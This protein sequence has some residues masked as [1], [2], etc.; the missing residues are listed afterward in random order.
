MP[1][2]VALI[3]DH[4]VMRA[5]LA[6]VVDAFQ[7]YKV[8]VQAANGH[9]FIQAL[10]GSEQPVIA[11]VDLNM[12]VMDGYETIA[13]LRTNRPGI[14]PLALTFSTDD[15]SMLKA[16]RAGARGFVTKTI[17]P[18][19]LKVVLDSLILTGYFHSDDL[20]AALVERQNFMTSEEREQQRM[21]ELISPRELE[22]LRL[23]C[24]PEEF[25][26]EQIAKQMDVHR[27]T[28]DGY[29]QG[30]MDKFGVKSKTGLVLCAM[31]LGVVKP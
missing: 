13:W 12:P 4:N 21:L 1:H 8:T 20:H 7:E 16:V 10:N 24:D 2:S 23:V 11:I 14:L 22:F 3:D 6:A 19:E 31:K 28:A 25:T 15:D 18:A 17:R 27:R 30:L 9:E 26:Y 29:R 5:G